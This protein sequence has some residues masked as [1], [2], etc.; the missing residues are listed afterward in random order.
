M[1][2]ITYLFFLLATSLLVVSCAETQSVHSKAIVV[3]THTDTP[4]QLINKGLDLGQRHAAPDSRVDYPR[5]REGEVDA[6]FFALFTS[7]R[8]RTEENYAHAYNL[9]HMM[10]DSTLKSVGAN[11]SMVEMAADLKDLELISSKDK[12]AIYFGIENGFPI[13]KDISRVKEFFDEGVRYITLCHSSNNDICD[14]S[15]DKDGPEHDGVSEF[16][17]EVIKEMNELGMIVDV[18]HISDKS[19]FDVLKLSKAP[20]MASHSSVRSLCDH[21]RNMDDDMIKALAA[22]DGVI[23][24]CILGNYIKEADTTSMNYIKKNELRLKYNNWKYKND[25]ERKQAWAE[26][27]KINKEY[28]A[29]LPTVA[30]AVD[31]IDY[32]KNLVGVDYVGIGSDFDGGGGLADCADVS[33]FPNITNELIARG[34]T[35]EEILKIWGGNFMR[36]FKAVE[37]VAMK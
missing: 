9:T 29:V 5:L 33:E 25:E 13:A 28:P 31:H 2:R 8:D 20:V 21:P 24:I 1:M 15:T 36:V 30:D 14:S 32:V 17:K 6:I 22:N 11:A 23:Q 18:S 37:K 34:Y 35:D 4:M 16:G 12:T 7:Q 3:D 27:D 10:I 26:Y 19:F